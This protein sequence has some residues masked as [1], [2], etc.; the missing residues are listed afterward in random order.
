LDYF[1][2]EE[3]GILRNI[4]YFIFVGL[5]AFLILFLVEFRVFEVLY[6]YIRMV[7]RAVAGMISPRLVRRPPPLRSD[8]DDDPDVKA[9][10]EHVNSMLSHDYQNYNLIMKNVSKYYKD[11]LAVNQLCIGIKTGECFGL[12]GVNGAGKTSTFKMLTGDAK[13]SNGEA[14]V[15]GIS[16]KMNMKEVHKRIGYCPQFDALIDDLSGRETLKLFALSRGIPKY[17]L[18]EVIAKLAQD[19]NF[20]K[21]LDKQVKAYSG[22][23]KRKLSTA[24][25]LLG[26][27]YIIYLDEPTTGM[28]VGSKRNLWDVMC[29]VRNAGKTIVL[30]SHSMEECEALC[31]RL[32]IMV[33]GQFKC[34]GSTQHLKTKFG[35]GFVLT[36]KIKRTEST[37]DDTESSD[38][39]SERNLVK[40]FVDEEFEGAVLK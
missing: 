10:K 38:M 15:Q 1:A 34:L 32:A 11:F 2:W 27:P 28:D 16:L 17:K 19:L 31:T 40:E 37:G 5:S 23:N 36:I 25:A 24:V 12:L 4:V 7:Y 21:H 39:S 22:G 30:T 35:R 6:Y 14:F 13:I 8:Y 18:K 3:P 29:S 33:N 20:T 26:N 9:E